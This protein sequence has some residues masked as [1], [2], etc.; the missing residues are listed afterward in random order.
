MTSRGAASTPRR[1]ALL[2]ASATL[3]L[4]LPAVYADA[5]LKPPGAVGVT[6]A[7]T[8]YLQ[9]SWKDR[10]RGES[11][12]RV[13]LLADGETV[14]ARKVGPNKRRATIRGLRRGTRYGVSVL[15]CGKVGKC[16]KRRSGKPAATLLAP[17]NGPH[18][19]LQCEAFPA[20]DDLNTP[21]ASR[22][23]A[24]NSNQIIA[25]LGGDLHP[26]FGSNPSYGIP[27]VVVP[28]GQPGARIHF[29]AYGDESDPG[30]YPI[31]PGAP[32]EGGR[33]AD[34]DRHVL[35]VERPPAPGG[36]CTLYELYRSFERRGTSN[37]WDGDAGAIFDLGSPLLGQRR[38]GWT[39]ADAAGLPIFPGL[40]TYE[41]V[42]SGVIDHA[43]RMTFE[44]TRRGYFPPATHYASDSCSDARPAMGE[45]LRLRGSYDISGISGDAKVIATALKKYGAIVADNGSDFYISGSADRR[46][47]DENLNQL[48]RIPGSA[49]EVVMPGRP[50][51]SGC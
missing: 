28:P 30:P 6:Q 41:E 48:K 10:S 5:K 35:V 4:L 31:P 17:F 14:V 50:L 51:V 32:I 44:E 42:K 19:D 46:W 49:F 43:I 23:R 16:R 22:P 34:G 33:H 15:T 12:Y 11:G 36:A 20:G 13:E 9:V 38:A 18:P 1:L 37:L 3:A 2:A 27:Y 45:R 47:N 26:D 39:S 24:A 25:R 8:R 29:T 40:V 7:G 21:V